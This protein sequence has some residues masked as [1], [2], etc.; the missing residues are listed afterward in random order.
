MGL[1]LFIYICNQWH[2]SA[3]GYANAYKSTPP[4]G[5]YMISVAIE[6]WN[7]NYKYLS[8]AAFTIPISV[9]GIFMGAL[10]D[11]VNRK[12]MLTAACVMWSLMTG[13]QATAKHIWTIY[14]CRFMVGVF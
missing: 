10:S 11:R 3:L 9:V 2:R 4:D 8:G 12:F 5:Y 14:V 13:L 7:E 1:V 6:S